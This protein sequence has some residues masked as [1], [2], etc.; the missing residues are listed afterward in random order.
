MNYPAVK[1]AA[2]RMDE[3][4]LRLSE[5]F[6][7]IHTGRANASLVEH[8]MVSNY[9]QLVPLKAVASLTI[10]EPNQ[11][12]IT[13]WD[14]DQLGAIDTAIREAGLGL[15]P[16]NDGKSVRVTLPPL[17]QER[18]QDLIKQVNR[19]AEEARIALRDLRR[20]A[21]DQV[22]QDPESTEDDKFDVTKE[23]DDLIGQYN[24]KVELAVKAKEQDLL[25][26]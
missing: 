10:P 23:L 16:T 19:I 13:P 17:T 9:G 1:Q 26:V 18:R 11:I 14:K 8:V 6:Q 24:D 5:E 21:V 12:A 3:V 22:R 4:L 2:V 15:N 20:D 25:I 7:K